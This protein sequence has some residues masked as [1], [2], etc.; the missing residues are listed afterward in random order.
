MKPFAEW[1]SGM[2]DSIEDGSYFH[3]DDLEHPAQASVE[4]TALQ[5]RM[6]IADLLV[7]NQS[8]EN[9]VTDWLTCFCVSLSGSTFGDRNITDTHLRNFVSVDLVTEWVHTEGDAANAA[10]LL[11][12]KNDIKNGMKSV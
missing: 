8:T 5:T 1:V 10:W 12:F 4:L 2:A 6:L 9:L 11:R 3:R 7:P